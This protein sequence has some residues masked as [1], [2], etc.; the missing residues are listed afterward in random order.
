MYL[1]NTE[2]F[3]TWRESA[4]ELLRRNVLPEDI[5]WQRDKQESLFAG[6]GQDWQQLPVETDVPCIPRDFFRLAKNVACYRDESR[7]SL[8]YTVAWRLVYEDKCLLEM[9]IDRHVSEIFT[10]HKR[11]AR[12]IHK[13]EAFV[14][15]RRV[16]ID[17]V[18][19]TDAAEIERESYVAWFEPDHLILPLA[20]PFFVNRF[21]TMSWSI[22]TP[23]LCAHWDGSQLYYTEGIAK[24]AALEDELEELWRQYYASIFNPA[25]LKL[26]AMQSEM[27]K[28]YWKNLPEADLIHELSRNATRQSQAMIEAPTSE[29]WQKTE[30][31]QWMQKKR[32]QLR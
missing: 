10:M 7:W 5:A 28:K 13:M 14:R 29:A 15:F 4:R 25:R 31:S 1:V 22:L 30:K 23:D 26:K 16:D 21:H 17:T 24:P 11:I 27:P 18:K 32:R 9:K 2:N 8:L 20:A 12:D 3:E 19:N 6:V